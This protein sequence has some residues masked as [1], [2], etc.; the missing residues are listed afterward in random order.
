MLVSQ[1]NLALI[2][3]GSQ[4]IEADDFVLEKNFTKQTVAAFAEKNLFVNGGEASYV[5]YSSSVVTS[6][7]FNS[8]ADFNEFVDAD[9]QARSSTRTAEGI[10]EGTEVLLTN[11]ASAFQDEPIIAAD[12]AR[13][14]G[15]EVFAVGVG[16]CSCDIESVL[17][18]ILASD[19]GS[20][21]P[22][23]STS[24]TV[25]A[26][27]RLAVI[28]TPTLGGSISGE[29]VTFTAAD[30]ED[31]ATEFEVVL[32]ACS[33]SPGSTVIDS[34][35][36]TDDQGNDPDL[37]RLTS[38][39]VGN[40]FCDERLTASPAPFPSQTPMMPTT[41]TPTTS[42]APTPAPMPTKTPATIAPQ[43]P[44]QAPTGTPTTAPAP[45]R[46]TTPAPFKAATPA[47]SKAPTQAPAKVFTIAPSSARTK[48]PT[49]APIET[50]TSPPSKTS[51]LAPTKVTTLSPAPVP[52][53]LPT[54]APVATPTRRNPT[55][56]PAEPTT[57]G[58]LG[59]DFAKDASYVG[60]YVSDPKNKVLTFKEASRSMTADVRLENAS[61]EYCTVLGLRCVECSW[62]SW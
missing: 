34:A 36:Y 47:P 33:L 30:L 42:K 24:V 5:Q 14:E 6:A 45:T 17:E 46:S 29:T 49:T 15:I 1:V 26:E 58:N 53:K 28:S 9:P 3:D 23:P 21:I 44:T 51:T 43:L 50:F 60:C 61:L 35:T 25:V 37:S 13:A 10:E 27:F 40:D 48:L 19:G 52:T 18:R 8:V 16:G 31:T 4:S 22:C 57:D 7:T 54:S 20:S 38:I 62:Y 2:V 11:P 59:E 55:T 12:A 41:P 39:A 56:A 32:D